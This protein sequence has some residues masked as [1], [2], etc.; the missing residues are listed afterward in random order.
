MHVSVISI[1]VSDQDRAKKFY[2]EVLGFK[3]LADMQMKP[4]MRWIHLTPPD[5]GATI[6]LVTWFPT[7]PPGSLRGLVLEVD[8][9]DTRHKE[10][11]AQGHNSPE[12]I[13]AEP[14][15]RYV[16]V[17]DPDGNGIVLQ[18]S[19]RNATRQSRPNPT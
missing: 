5:G 1:P 16:T 19:T 14:W 7:M 9:I 17:N 12:G 2:V 15:G 8:D 6:T 3:E 10:L 13:Q 11:A 18:T 4:D